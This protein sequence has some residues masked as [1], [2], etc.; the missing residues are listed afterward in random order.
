MLSTEI[1]II[2]KESQSFLGCFAIDM[3]PPFPKLLPASLIVNTDTSG[4]S[5]E[6]WL[7]LILHKDECFY[8]DSFGLPILEEQLIRYLEPHYD[9]V[10]YSDVC[11]QHLESI[12]CGKFCIAFIKYVNSKLEYYNFLSCFN[13]LNLRKNDMIIEYLL[14]AI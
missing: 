14:S 1:N 13:Q 12:N 7:A 2:L 10:F 6:H 3:L 9:L 8:F 4:G 5:G 11:I